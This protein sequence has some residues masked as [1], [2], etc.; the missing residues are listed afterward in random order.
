MEYTVKSNINHNGTAYAKGSVVDASMFTEAELAQLV[1]DGVLSTT[2]VETSPDVQT[3]EAPA[4]E[5]PLVQ[6]P[7]VSDLEEQIET[8]PTPVAVQTEEVVPPLQQ[9]IPKDPKQPTPE[10][11]DATLQNIEQPSD[12]L[13]PVQLG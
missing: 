2:L 6:P 3:E 10:E 13:P 7:A 11:I 1:E 9:P 8:T 4:T 5:A 12:G